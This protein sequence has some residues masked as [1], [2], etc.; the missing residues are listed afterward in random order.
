MLIGVERVEDRKVIV[1]ATNSDD[2]NLEGKRM[3]RL[4]LSIV[5]ILVAMLSLNI[6]LAAAANPH[7]VT[8]SDAVDAAGNLDCG[9]KVAG[10]GAN[11]TISVTCTADANAVY[12]CINKG[13]KNPSAANKQAEA[14]PVSG[15]GE[16]TSGKNGQVTGSVEAEPPPSTLDCPKGQTFQVCAVSYTNVVLEAAD[17]T[18]NLPDVSKNFNVASNCP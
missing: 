15:S 16:F 18:A 17:S 1:D 8:A 3:K 13:G 2:S 7:F 10:L 9:F 4:L 14:G 12:G 11:E 5:V 6:G